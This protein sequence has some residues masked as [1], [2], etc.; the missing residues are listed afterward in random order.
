MDSRE[1]TVYVLIRPGCREFLAEVSKI[2][3]VVIYTASLSQYA[4]PLMDIIDP[5]NLC[6]ARLFR[7][8]CTQIDGV[9]AKD[10]SQLGRSLRDLI[11]IDNSPNSYKLQQQNALPISSWYDDQEDYELSWLV[12]FLQGLV[13]VPDVRSILSKCVVLQPKETLSEDIIDMHYGMELLKPYF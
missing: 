9:Y 7:E 13:L 12:P 8:H 1:F 5:Q 6:T 2:Y 3:E 10:L 11:L 4:D